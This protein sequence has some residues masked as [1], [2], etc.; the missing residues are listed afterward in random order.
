MASVILLPLLGLTW[1]FG[2]L[3]VNEETKV[4]AWLFTIFNSLQV[5]AKMCTCLN[6]LI[7]LT[8]SNAINV[9]I[10]SVLYITHCPGY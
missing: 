7:Q 4:F 5:R 2:L 3:A 6:S 1:V 8:I 10:K 9:I